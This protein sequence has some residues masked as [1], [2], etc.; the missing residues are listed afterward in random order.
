MINL[1]CEELL[2]ECVAASLYGNEK[3]K[4]NAEAL[5]FSILK[6]QSNFICRVS[7]PEPGMSARQYYKDLREKFVAAV[8]EK[9]D[10]VHNL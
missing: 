7:H 3:N 1:V 2:I 10:Q 4:D 8:S 9:A 5:M 6:L